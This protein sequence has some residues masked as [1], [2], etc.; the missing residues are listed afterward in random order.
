[1][2]IHVVLVRSEYEGNVGSS[3][4]SA[5]NMGADSLILIAPQ[6]DHLAHESRQMAAGA[7]E[8]LKSA[9]V[10]SDWNSFYSAEGQGVRIAFSR[11]DGKRRKAIE[12]SHAGTS[13]INRESTDH[14]YLIF[15]PE[16]DG[17]DHEDLAF[18]NLT[19]SLPTFGNF[20]SFNLSQAVIVALTVLQLQTMKSSPPTNEENPPAP[21]YFPDDLIKKWLTQ[22]GF[23]IQARKASAYLTLK[24]LFLLN[25][26]TKHEIKVLEATLQQTLRKLDEASFGLSFEQIADHRSDIVSEDI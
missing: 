5:A 26:P 15:G 4:R 1:M 8:M 12:W 7:Q 18:V 19:C 17:L 20:A 24:R 13:L 21:F 2:K 11:R 22:I 16:A 25:Q 3:A 23:D 6:V 10:Y 9:R 14:L